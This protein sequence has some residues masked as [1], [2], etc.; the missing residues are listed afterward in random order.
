MLSET[1]SQYSAAM[2]MEKVFGQET[3]AKLLR[4]EGR[5]YLMSRSMESKREWPLALNENQGYIHYNKGLL[6]MYAL[7]E[8]VGEDALN[9][10]IKKFADKVRYQE[11]PFTTSL[12]FV[13]SLKAD[14]GPQLH[15]LIDELFNKVV[16]YDNRLQSHKL[17]E[18]LDGSVT[19]DLEVLGRKIDVDD[20]GAQ[21]DM[22]FTQELEFAGRDAQDKNLGAERRLIRN[23][24][25]NIQLKF[26]QKPKSLLLDPRSIWIDLNRDDNKLPL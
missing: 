19:I 13:A 14:L 4:Y 7:K 20:K 6:V 10:A 12:D 11:P 17:T 18:H 21:T 25:N 23:G 5:D 2:V 16:L 15:A 22:D 9:A 26:A 8:A 3:T 1:L 24:V